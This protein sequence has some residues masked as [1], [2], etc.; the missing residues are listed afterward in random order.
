MSRSRA[1]ALFWFGTGVVDTLLAARDFA[2]AI[3]YLRQCR[4]H[5]RRA[6]RAERR[7]SV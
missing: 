4:R 2:G 3:H 5:L 7:P 1:L 6:E